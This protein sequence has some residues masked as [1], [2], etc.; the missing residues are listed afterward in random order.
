MEISDE[1]DAEISTERRC[2][3]YFIK[4]GTHK[5]CPNQEKIKSG[6]QCEECQKD[7][8]FRPFVMGKQSFSAERN[9]F[10]EEEFCVYLVLFGSKLKVGICNADRYPTR[11]I[12]QGADKSTV[13]HKASDAKEALSIEGSIKSKASIS[14]RV[15]A[16]EKIKQLNKEAASKRFT[17]AKNTIQKKLDIIPLNQEI[18][19]LTP[20][21]VGSTETSEDYN[22]AD[23]SKS[24]ALNEKIKAVK[25]QFIFTDKNRV[26][27]IS[28]FSGRV[29][30]KRKQQGLSDFN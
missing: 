6:S 15:Y 18:Q 3:G 4:P 20:H 27:N 13:V 25:G 8:L 7:D 14:D 28:A 9:E 2:I 19:V 23:S 21:Y 10:F 11:C 26:I 16:R 24:V 12:D 5:P 29:I 1:L 17:N 30:K 22:L